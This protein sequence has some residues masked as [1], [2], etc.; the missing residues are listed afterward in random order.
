LEQFERSGQLIKGKWRIDARLG[1]GSTASVYAATHRNG[2]RVAMKVLHSDLAGNADIRARFLREGYVAN[3]IRHPGVVRILDDDVMDDGAVF[4]VMELLEGETLEA[5]A[6]RFGGKLPL[7]DVIPTMDR[8]LDV[9]AAAHAQG[10]VHRDV[11]P[12]NVFLTKEGGLKVLDFGLARIS[13]AIGSRM[14]TR[15]GLILGTPDFM[16]PEQ[17]SGNSGAVDPRSDLW[18]VGATA[19][20]LLTN[21]PVHKSGTLHEYL[22]V[23]ASVPARSLSLAAPNVPRSVVE[24]I[25]RSLALD[26]AHRWGS[27]REMQAALREAYPL[28][29]EQSL[30]VG[31]LIQRPA[32]PTS[33]DRPMPSSVRFD[34][35]ITVTELAGAA[36]VAIATVEGTAGEDPVSAAPTINELQLAPLR[37]AASRNMPIPPAAGMPVTTERHPQAPGPSHM[38]PPVQVY[39]QP[40]AHQPVVPGIATRDFSDFS[41]ITTNRQFKPVEPWLPRLMIL[42]MILIVLGVVFVGI[43]LK[44]RALRHPPSATAPSATTAQH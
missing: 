33:I 10:I 25:D 7:D 15:A 43:S 5:R 8:L 36:A 17:A 1:D 34:R 40:Y 16:S 12:D 28:T 3:T 22:Q 38:Q 2:Y 30:E 9:L 39:N 24:V 19:F 20:T 21:E 29:A 4:L 42:L 14:S 18:S 11:K 44:R 6:M 27:A 23:I 13:E 26:R 32:T 31:V 37:E 41:S 35:D